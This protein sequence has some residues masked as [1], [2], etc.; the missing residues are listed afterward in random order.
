MQNMHHHQ[1]YAKHHRRVLNN[2]N[3]QKATKSS[4][5]TRHCS[6]PIMESSHLVPNPFS[7]FPTLL[8]VTHQSPLLLLTPSVLLLV[9]STRPGSTL[10]VLQGRGVCGVMLTATLVTVADV[11]LITKQATPALAAAA[12]HSLADAPQCL[13]TLT[14][15]LFPSCLR[16][17]LILMLP[18]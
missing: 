3:Q 18:F 4:F 6:Q 10:S 15:L 12:S 16:M 1:I 13:C 11:S 7:P 14:P 8:P 5:N 2:K 9:L 17:F